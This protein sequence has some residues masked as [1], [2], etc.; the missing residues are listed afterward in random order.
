ML[1]LIPFKGPLTF[2]CQ[3]QDGRAV[4]GLSRLIT[5]PLC[6]QISFNYAQQLKGEEEEAEGSLSTFFSFI[7]CSSHCSSKST[8]TWFKRVPRYGALFLPLSVPGL[9][10]APHPIGGK[11]VC[12]LVGYI[13]F[14][15]VV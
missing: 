5:A 9:S 4:L 13:D 3:F 11:G 1:Q 8:K 2:S 15:I 6:S 10:T 14:C 12:I 7:L